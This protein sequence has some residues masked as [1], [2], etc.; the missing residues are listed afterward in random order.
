ML[1]HCGEPAKVVCVL[2]VVVVQMKELYARIPH[3]A[4]E[5]LF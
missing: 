5:T 2:D 3:K 4:L 1:Q